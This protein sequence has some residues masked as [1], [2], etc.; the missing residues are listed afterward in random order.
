[1]LPLF[2][3]GMAVAI[4]V[5][6]RSRR[7]IVLG[8]AASLG[9]WLVI[10]GWWYLRNTLLYGDTL[11]VGVHIA[12]FGRTGGL[13]GWNLLEQW[14][15]TSTSFWAA[16]GWGNVQFP[17]WIYVVVRGLE[18]IAAAGL[19]TFL[20][21][22]RRTLRD[23]A[24]WLALA[25]YVLLSVAAY[26]W[27]TVTVTATLGRLL[28]P[29]LAPLAVF[30]CIGLKQWSPRLL[31]AGWAFVA[32]LALLAPTAII[33]AY[34]LPPVMFQS[35]SLGHSVDAVAT[36]SD[37]ARLQSVEV[38]PSR[39][40]PGQAVSV[41]ACW[42]P[43]RT[44]DQDYAFFV[45]ILGE[46]DRKIGERTSWPGLGR[47]PTS[48]WQPGRPFCDEVDVPTRPDAAAAAVYPVVLGLLDMQTGESLPLTDASGQ[49]IS[50]L[51]AV[52]VKLMGA[53]RR[54]AAVSRAAGCQLR[55]QAGVDRLSDR[56]AQRRQAK[57]R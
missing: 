33:T 43:L 57:R 14:Q 31:A 27:W 2:G 38:T 6:R 15:W 56:A 1:M 7:T 30:V 36:V 54:T 40:A 20:A 49:P 44:T 41:R 47:Y 4:G 28:F 12:S 39:L 21:I 5:K 19:V 16:F 34:T 52:Q 11:G 24:A 29:V 35:A 50:Q 10:A 32:C 17:G 51:V 53:G 37:L 18:V 23:R 26:L 42:Q 13:V 55:G 25:G 46:D 8:V 48:Q 45:Q 22:R 3:A 9:L